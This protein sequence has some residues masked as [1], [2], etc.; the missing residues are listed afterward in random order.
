MT[1]TETLRH[2]LGWALRTAL[3]LLITVIIGLEVLQVFLRYLFASGVVWGRDVSTLLLFSIAWL[4]APLLWLERRHLAVDLLPSRLTG[5]SYWLRG[6][7]LLMLVAA[8]ALFIQIRSA[9]QAFAFI[10][11]PSLGTSAAIKF[12]P[13]GL[14]TCLLALAAVL[15]MVR[16]QPE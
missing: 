13:M 16:T 11:L 4:G 12:W 7:D 8:I 2:H 6:L 15:N 1:K 10:D 5:A 9:M 3:G 14:G